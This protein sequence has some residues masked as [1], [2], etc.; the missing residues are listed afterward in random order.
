MAIVSEQISK[1]GGEDVLVVDTFPRGIAGEL[2]SILPRID[3]FKVWVHRDLHPAYVEKWNLRTCRSDFDVIIVPGEPAPLDQVADHMTPPWTICDFDE[4]FEPREA[5]SVFGI[6]AHDDR[7]LIVVSGTGTLA[8]SRDAAALAV[9]LNRR[10][11]AQGIVRFTSLSQDA[12]AAAK[13]LGVSVWPLMRLLPGVDLLVGS[14]GYNTVYEARLAGCRI[15]AFPQKRLYDRQA[16]RI[17]LSERME[18]LEELASI[19]VRLC[20]SPCRV[21]RNSPKFDNGAVAAF[22]IIAERIASKRHGI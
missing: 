22:G 12:I 8:E 3:A 10:V 21:I 18:N 13:P 15:A 2:Q 1:C 11:E 5:R 20:Q 4:L 17:E 14:A 19:S 9:E 16:R 6:G 7:S